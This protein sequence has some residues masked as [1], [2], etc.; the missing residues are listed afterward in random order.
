MRSIAPFCTRPITSERSIVNQTAP[1]APAAIAVGNFSV[2]GMRYS[3]NCGPPRKRNAT[4]ACEHDSGER[5]HDDQAVAARQRNLHG[6][7]GRA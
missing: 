3:T 1:S 7:Q 2:S 5:E 4:V 6:D